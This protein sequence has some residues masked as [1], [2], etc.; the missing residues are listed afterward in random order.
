L[1]T[2][3]RRGLEERSKVGSRHGFPVFEV[4]PDSPPRQVTDAYVLALVQR[5]NGALATFD[6]GIAELIAGTERT[7]CVTVVDVQ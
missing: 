4:S 6:R 1:Q 7:R 3:A 2:N 5:Y